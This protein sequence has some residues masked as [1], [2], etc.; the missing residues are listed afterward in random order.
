[1]AGVP[2]PAASAA[3]VDALAAVAG[4]DLDAAELHAAAG[5]VLNQINETIADSEEYRELVSRLE[6][7]FD[8]ELTTPFDFSDLPSGDELAAELERFLRGEQG[9]Q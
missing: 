6:A 7:A 4:L 9:E 5:S 3:L 8:G 2:Y 1:L